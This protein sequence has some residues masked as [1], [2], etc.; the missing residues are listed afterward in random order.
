MDGRIVFTDE[1]GLPLY[2]PRRWSFSGEAI[3]GFARSGYSFAAS[4][5]GDITVYT[6]TSH[7]LTPSVVPFGA[8][9]ITVA[10]S[11]CFVAPLGRIGVMILSAGAL[12]GDFIGVLAPEREDTY[13]CRVVAQPG[14]NDRDLL[15]CATRRGGIGVTEV[16]WGEDTYSMRTATFPGLDVV[17]VCT[18]G[19]EPDAPAIAAV[20]VDGKLILVRDALHDKNPLTV[21]FD[22]VQGTAY[23]LLSAGGDLFLLT[24]RGL[25]GL[26][27]LGE[28][29]MHGSPA[30]QFITPIFVVPMEAVDANLVAGRWLLVTMPDE[31]Q[32]FDVEQLAGGIPEGLGESE[33]KEVSPTTLRPNWEISDVSQ[34]SRQL[35][36]VAG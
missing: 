7:P 30:E 31:V 2:E 18:V 19:G 10:P 20:G 9:G 22:T 25:Y 27:G 4:S 15:A 14:R 5:R 17:D 36:P 1:A 35:A 29:L 12:P 11:G 8:H 24:S 33:L 23:R 32:K 28:R 16:R 6:E 26:M 21:K 3:S 13:F 34:R